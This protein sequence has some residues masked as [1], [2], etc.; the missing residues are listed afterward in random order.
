MTDRKPMHRP[1][2]ADWCQ[3]TR[4]LLGWPSGTPEHWHDLYAAGA[5][6]L[7]AARQ[8]VFGHEG[9]GVD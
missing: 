5:T 8:T 2:F 6:P 4:L 9:V 3:H 7:Q 1:A